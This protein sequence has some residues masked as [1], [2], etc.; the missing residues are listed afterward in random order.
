MNIRRSAGYVS[1][2]CMPAHLHT[3]MHMPKSGLELS[4]FFHLLR[5]RWMGRSLRDGSAM[6]CR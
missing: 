6:S 2:I 1:L 5:L 3:I 4:D